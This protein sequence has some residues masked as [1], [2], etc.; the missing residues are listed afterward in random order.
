MSIGMLSIQFPLS[1]TEAQAI[2][3]KHLMVIA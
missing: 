3:D 2:R 1:E